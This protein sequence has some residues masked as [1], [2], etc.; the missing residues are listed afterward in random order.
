MRTKQIF[1][2]VTSRFIMNTLED[3]Y[4]YHN[5]KSPETFGK[6][7][8]TVCQ[9]LDQQLSLNEAISDS[10]IL[11]A[12]KSE[13]NRASGQSK[14]NSA[15]DAENGLDGDLSKASDAPFSP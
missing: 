13:T 15:T 5:L 1:K 6:M 10:R 11:K 8:V 2:E 4:L 12:L 9:D 14:A 3:I 7:C